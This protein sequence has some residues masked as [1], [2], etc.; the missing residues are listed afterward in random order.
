MED[1]K[2]SFYLIPITL[3][4]AG[5]LIALAVWSQSPAPDGA[6]PS[7]PIIEV[8]VGSLPALGDSDSPVVFI[9]F[10]DYQCPFCAEFLKETEGRLRDEFVAGG[11]MVMYW[12]DFAFLGSES[13]NAAQAARCAGEQ[14]KFWQYHDLL[15]L[16]QR[17]ENQGSFTKERLKGLA[18]DIELNQAGFRECLDSDRYLSLVEADTEVGRQLGLQGTPTVFIG[19][20]GDAEGILRGERIVGAQSYEAYLDVIQKYLR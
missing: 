18:E 17:G 5:G 19:V 1:T 11:K 9:E 20:P 13:Y 4:I 8:D 15:F 7:G 14:D 3:V 2:I 16:A 10:G 6:G 12:R